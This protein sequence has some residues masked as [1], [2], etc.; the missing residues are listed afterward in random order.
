MQTLHI[1]MQ[2]LKILDFRLLTLNNN[3]DLMI[4]RNFSK[5]CFVLLHLLHILI[6]S[7]FLITL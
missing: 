1:K 3:F 5:F 4:D 6:Y 2:F 7:L